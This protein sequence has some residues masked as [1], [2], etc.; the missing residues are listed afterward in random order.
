MAHRLRQ[1]LRKT[2][3]VQGR[4]TAR[5]PDEPLYQKLNLIRLAVRTR[6]FPWANA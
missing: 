4:G 3:K 6:T 1:W 2:H 5:Y